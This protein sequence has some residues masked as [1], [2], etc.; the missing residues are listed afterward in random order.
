[1]N[2]LVR[3]EIRLLLPSFATA[4]VL[5]FSVWLMPHDLSALSLPSLLLVFPF[6]LCHAMVVMMTLDS[7][8]R[9]LASGTFANL[10][11]QPIPRSRVWRTKTAVLAGALGLVF[12]A[13]WLSFLLFLGNSPVKM[14]EPQELPY[15][16]VISALFVLAIYAGGLWTV[17]LIRQVAAAFWFTLL[18]PSALAMV[19]AY[20]TEKYNSTV[21]TVGS[22]IFVLAAYSI[23]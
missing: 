8:G 5:T 13:W 10:L 15:T 11:A 16:L 3:K 17:L 7:F 9:E 4:V 19:V 14:V 21:F 20:F 6:M 1:M 23:A 2:T 22:L 12:V 18:V